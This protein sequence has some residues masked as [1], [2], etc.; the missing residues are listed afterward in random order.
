VVITGSKKHKQIICTFAPNSR[1]VTTASLPT[2]RF[3]KASFLPSKH[4]KT[5]KANQPIH[6]VIKCRSDSEIINL[7]YSKKS[8]LTLYKN[9]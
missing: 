6:N 3:L 9:C 4:V 8:C 5:L 2:L 7:L 1:E